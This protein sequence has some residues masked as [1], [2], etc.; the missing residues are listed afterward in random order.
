MLKWENEQQARDEIKSLVADFYHEFKE[1]KD[2]FKPGDRV[3]YAS[4]VF[5]EKEMQSLADAALAILPFC[6]GFL[7]GIG[8]AATAFSRRSS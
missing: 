5:D 2:T 3:A 1:N 6:P 8:F 4:R 7:S